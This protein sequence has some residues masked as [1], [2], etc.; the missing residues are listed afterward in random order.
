VR[1]RRLDDPGY[2]YS[3][4]EEARAIGEIFTDPEAAR[5]M[6]EIAEGYERLAERAAER[7]SNG[8]SRG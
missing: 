5:I 7:A 8:K 2:W 3:R 6:S 4:A 1:S